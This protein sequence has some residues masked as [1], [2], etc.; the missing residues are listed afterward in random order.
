MLI[1]SHNKT[2]DGKA[3]AVG[4]EEDDAADL[5]GAALGL[6]LGVLSDRAVVMDW[7]LGEF[8]GSNWSNTR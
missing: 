5:N 4:E 1:V 7:G 3:A 8:I 2:T 6:V